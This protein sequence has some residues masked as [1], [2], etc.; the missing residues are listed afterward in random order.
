MAKTKKETPAAPEVQAAI[1]PPKDE[2]EES[3]L[4]GFDMSKY[5]AKPIDTN[6][7]IK[8]KITTILSKKPNSQTYFQAHPKLEV[9]VD[10]LEWKEE[11]DL[12]LVNQE[13][14]VELFEQTKRVI[15]YVCINSKGDP[16][17]FPVPQPD[18]RGHWNSWHESASKAVSEAKGNWVRIQPNR[19]IAGYDTLI[20]EGNLAPPKWP[21]M[22]IEQYIG[23][24][25]ANRIIDSE[26]HPVVKQLRGLV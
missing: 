25:F 23:I 12:Y 21:D 20:A 6:L 16:F 4:P 3:P 8:K 1:T 19:S 17:L 2:A 26:D 13:K 18:S 15:L 10:T 5:V 11:N 22:T 7:V 14:L 24:A 9:T